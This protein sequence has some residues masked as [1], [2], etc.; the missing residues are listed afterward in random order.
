MYSFFN[1]FERLEYYYMYWFIFWLFQY[2]LI[3][4]SLLVLQIIAIVLWIMMNA[5]VCTLIQYLFESQKSIYMISI[6]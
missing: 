3:V 4:L 5:E 1:S 2:S 6:K